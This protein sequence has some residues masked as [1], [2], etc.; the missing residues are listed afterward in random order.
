M[1]GFDVADDWLDRRSPAHL[2][3]DGGRDAALLTDGEDREPVP[4]G[5]VVAAISGIGEDATDLV[6]DGALH[7][8]ND[9]RRRVPVIWIARQRHGVQG[10]LAALGALQRGGH[11]HLDAELVRGVR[12]ALSNAFDLMGMQGIDLAAA[13][14]LALL[15]D[16]SGLVE[17]PFEDRLQFLVAGVLALDVA[18]G[19]AQIGLQPAQRPVGALELFGVGIALMGDQRLLADPHIG[20]AQVEA[21]PLGQPHQPL[22]RPVDQ[23]GIGREHD[24]LGL[25]GGVDDHPPC[26]LRLHCPGPDRDRKALLQQRHDLVLTHALAP[27]RH[28][29]AVEW[30]LVP[31]ER[32]AAKI[33]E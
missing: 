14:A 4:A 25:H 11:R 9:G 3:L 13:L 23:L 5:S 33:L 1:L 2:A 18:D 29:G 10:E 31:E 15:H 30:Q 21:D 17:R 26:I 28:R 32:L 12:L 19:T 24:V 27:A 22:A 20:L 8:G 6:A 7:G 16:R